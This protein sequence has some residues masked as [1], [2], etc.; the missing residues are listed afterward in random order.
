MM[1]S[2]EKKLAGKTAVVT[3]AGRGIG[4]SIAIAFAKAGAN[5]AVCS[6]SADELASVREIIVAQGVSCV[7]GV[8]DLTDAKATGNF[9]SQTIAALGQV[10]IL[11]NN[12][13]G[14]LETSKIAE[15]DIEQW[16]R[17]VEVNIR[18]PYL[19]TRLFLDGLTDGG[20][21][22]NLSTGVALRA[23]N[24]NSAYHVAKAGLHM[25]TQALANELLPRR[26]DVNNLI[27]GPVATSIFDDRKDGKPSTPDEV[28]ARYAYELPLGLPEPL[29]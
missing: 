14:M 28:L 3:G 5:V 25:F 4:R 19:V 9:C 2:N 11:V 24:K 12:A 18:S 13:G 26:I 29:E 27:P 23:G 15:S 21:I 20:K 17:T 1:S 6:R 10:D 22:I 8:A 7:V 16:W